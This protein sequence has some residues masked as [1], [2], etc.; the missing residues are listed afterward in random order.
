[1]TAVHEWWKGRSHSTRGAVQVIAALLF[2]SIMLIIAI[3]I[4]NSEMSSISAENDSEIAVQRYITQHGT[5]AIG[6]EDSSGSSC[7][8]CAGEDTVPAGANDR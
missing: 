2:V 7:D 6:A 5:Y 1:M 3:I 4:F 8:Y